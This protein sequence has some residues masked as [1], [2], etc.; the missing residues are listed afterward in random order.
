MKQ[1]TK[2]EKYYHW[3]CFYEVHVLKNPFGLQIINY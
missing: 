1:N 2:I 3:Y